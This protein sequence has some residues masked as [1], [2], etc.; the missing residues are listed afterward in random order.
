IGKEKIDSLRTTG[1]IECS[2][3]FFTGN[4]MTLPFPD[5]YFDAAFHFGGINV[6]SDE[7]KAVAEMARVVRKGGRVVY[8][9]EG[10]APWLR[11]TDYG[12]I[13]MNSSPLY[14][15]ETPLATVPSSARDVSV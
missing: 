5:G 4:A 10:L 14:A 15:Y 12:R 11:D 8:G 3:E 9:D 7:A 13:L 2:V 6:F 1:E